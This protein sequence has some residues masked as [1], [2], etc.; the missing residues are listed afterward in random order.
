MAG[1]SAII[2]RSGVDRETVERVFRAVF[3][4]LLEGERVLVPNFGAFV[5]KD[6]KPR[7][8]R[9]NILPDG[10]INVPPKRTIRFRPSVAM[11]DKLESPEAQAFERST[12]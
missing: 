2:E 6:L 1:I 5:I 4:L 3:E 12:W 10:E 7:R 11:R 8:I 9:S